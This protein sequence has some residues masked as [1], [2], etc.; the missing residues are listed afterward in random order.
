MNNVDLVKFSTSKLIL[1]YVILQKGI[2]RAKFTKI[3]AGFDDVHYERSY[4][5]GENIKL[6]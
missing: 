5:T 6:V 2:V 3:L 1:G 4:A